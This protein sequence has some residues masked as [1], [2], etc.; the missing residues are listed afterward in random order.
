VG[1][2]G[3][4]VKLNIPFAQFGKDFPGLGHFL[5]SVPIRWAPPSALPTFGIPQ[6]V[7]C[8]RP[9]LASSHFGVTEAK[10]AK[11]VYLEPASDL[12]INKFIRANFFK[13]AREPFRAHGGEASHSGVAREVVALLDDEFEQK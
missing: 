4:V 1:R 12:I 10:A 9:R 2:D 3:S 6:H 7:F 13:I 5:E 11:V 8:I